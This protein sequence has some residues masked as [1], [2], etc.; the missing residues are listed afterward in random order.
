[1]TVDDG[2]VPYLDGHCST[3]G[4]PDQ[5]HGLCPGHYR[6]QLGVEHLCSCPEHANDKKETV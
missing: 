5:F 2:P 1:M 6:S 3:R 4:K